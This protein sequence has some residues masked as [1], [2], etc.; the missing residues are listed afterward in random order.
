MRKADGN[1]EKYD[2]HVVDFAIDRLRAGARVALVTLVKIEGSSPWPLGAQ[3]AV[4]ESG[5]WVGY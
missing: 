2:D 5:E 1:W 4:S 3:M